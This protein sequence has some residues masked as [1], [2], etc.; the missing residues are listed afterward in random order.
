MKKLNDKKTQYKSLMEF[1][2]LADENETINLSTK[3]GTK[4]PEKKEVL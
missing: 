1:A 3:I 2:L 4:K